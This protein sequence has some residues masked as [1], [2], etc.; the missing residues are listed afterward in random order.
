M[1]RNIGTFILS[2]IM[3]I[4]YNNTFGFNCRRYEVGNNLILISHET[5]GDTIRD[6]DGNLYTT[7]TIG[8]QVWLLENLKTTRYNDG[9]Y[10]PLVRVDAEW[11][12][13][14]TPGYCWYNNDSV[15]NKNIYGAL[16]NWYAVN[17]GKLC[18]K[19]WHVPTD[20]EWTILGSYLGGETTV[21]RGEDTPSGGKMK[22]AD[23]TH[24]AS[25]NT[26]ANNSS[27]FTALPAGTRGGGSGTFRVLGSYTGW[28]TSSE[29]LPSYAWYRTIS[30]A[31]STI[32]RDFGH[33][34]TTGFSVRCL[35]N[36]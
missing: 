26:G 21:M 3:L 16:Y 23:T 14:S 15:K 25:P 29:A 11:G 12:K 1:R 7:I 19:G 17:T 9:T 35:R 20:Q 5:S 2:C 36:N 22:E 32:N 27:G 8:T 28:W 24:W 33:L 4:L 34:E 10:I 31:S 6:A 13:L 30:F 18:P